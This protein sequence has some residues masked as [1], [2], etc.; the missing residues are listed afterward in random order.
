MK[1]RSNNRYNEREFYT[2]DIGEAAALLTAHIQLIRLEREN[3]FFWF[4][5]ENKDCELIRSAYWSGELNQSVKL[6]NANLRWLKDRVFAQ[7]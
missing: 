1:Q 6:Y 5:F 3:T 7:R 2:K 4:V